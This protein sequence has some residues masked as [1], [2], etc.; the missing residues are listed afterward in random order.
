MA[1][2]TLTPVLIDTTTPTNWKRIGGFV[3]VGAGAA[4]AVV[5]VVSMVQVNSVQNDKDF[6]DYAAQYSSSTNVCDR[7]RGDGAPA[8]PNAAVADLCDKAG[9]F[10]LLQAIFF[11]L[12]AVSAGVGTYLILT[13]DEEAPESAPKAGWTV[14][15][16]VG[17][18]AGKLS[19]TYRW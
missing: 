16:Y 11:P 8:A 17:T 12:A 4:F 5:G 18:D 3:G 6:T 15:P 19:A 9:T 1:D 2:V 7:A 14:Q 13:S 10:S